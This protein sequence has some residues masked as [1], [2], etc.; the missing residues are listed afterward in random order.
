MKIYYSLGRSAI[1][2][3]EVPEDEAKPISTNVIKQVESSFL[4]VVI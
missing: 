1:V 2:E 3:G 4:R